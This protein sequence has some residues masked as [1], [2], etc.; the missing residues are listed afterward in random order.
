M[1]QNSKKDLQLDAATGKRSRQQSAAVSSHG[2]IVDQQIAALLNR[3]EKSSSLLI[4]YLVV[5]VRE[6]IQYA[7]SST[8]AEVVR[9]FGI[10][11]R[12]L[13]PVASNLS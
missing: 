8:T 2:I 1:R 4:E 10:S 13:R 6:Y 5:I 9:Y 12:N 7:L 3:R 11:Q